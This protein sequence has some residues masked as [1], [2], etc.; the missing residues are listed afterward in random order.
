METAWKPYFPKN[1]RGVLHREDNKSATA[2]K[3]LS[4]H[5]K[6]LTGKGGKRANLSETDLY[7]SNL[8]GADLSCANLKATRLC[9]ANLS[10]ANLKNANLSDARISY[11]NLLEAKLSDVDLSNANLQGVI[12]PGQI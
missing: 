1:H 6:W 8:S 12:C 11:A 9:H 5:G 2:K 4:E 10:G 3:M 7:G